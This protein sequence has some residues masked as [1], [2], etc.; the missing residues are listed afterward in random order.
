M[1]KWLQTSSLSLH[2]VYSKIKALLSTFVQPISLDVTK[3]ITE[4]ANVR[5]LEEAVPLFLGTDFQ[6]HYLQCQDHAL[7]TTAQLNAAS[8]VM[9]DYIYKIADSIEKRFPEID[10]MLTNTVF[11][12]PPLRNLQ[13]PDMQAMLNR[14]GQESGPVAFPLDRVIMQFHLYQNDSSIDIQF[15]ACNKDPVVFWCQLYEE[16]DYKELASLALLLYTTLNIS[17]VSPL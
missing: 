10:F 5:C 12:E 6:Q 17:Y 9:Y 4:S 2:E 15:S 13:Q 1:N 14:F 3:S 7:L 8:K 16:G 11:L